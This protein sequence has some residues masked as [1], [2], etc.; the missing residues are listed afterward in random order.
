MASLRELLSASLEGRRFAA[1]LVAQTLALFVLP[2]WATM[3][4]EFLYFQIS[5]ALVLSASLYAASARQGWLVIAGA[6]LLPAAYAWLGPDLLSQT[7]D[8]I[9]RLLTIAASLLFTAGIVASSLMQHDRVN[10]D[11]LMGGVN[12]YLLL[13]FAFAL[14]HASLEV[15]RH[16]SYTIHGRGLIEHTD[17]AYGGRSFPTIVYFSVT[18][19]STLGYGDIVPAT[20]AARMLTSVQALIG[21]L[22]IAIFIGRMVGIQVAERMAMRGQPEQAGPPA[23]ASSDAPP[24]REDA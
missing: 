11:T 13:V 19:L 1:L 21:Q 14:A 10:R 8:D 7:T 4:T 15:A 3:E 16:E 5:V 12:V 18:T 23:P 9:L 2:L 6:L 24:E 22:Y 20:E 17:E